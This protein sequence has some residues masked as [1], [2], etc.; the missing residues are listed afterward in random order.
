M[1]YTHQLR[2]DG[3]GAQYQSIIT[4]YI[5]C[6]ENNLNYLYRPFYSVEHNYENDTMYSNK[7]EELINV[8][9]NIPNK[10]EIVCQQIMGHKSIQLFE[11]NMDEYCNSESM[12]FIKNCFWKNKDR[13]HFKNDKLNIAVQIRRENIHD[14]GQ[15]GE[16]STTPNEYYLRIMNEIRE[17]NKEQDKIVQFHI[18]SQGD[19]INFK[20]LENDDVEFHLNE[21]ITTTFIG[22]VAAE[23]L[24]ISPSSFSYV[25]GLLSDG[26]VYYKKFWHLP[27]KEWIISG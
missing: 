14:K 18:Y 9:D 8:K 21:E 11:D 24:I 10:N 13:N 7:L 26:I 15:S 16:R 12:Q 19:L 6:N 20:I 22:L 17:K 5:Y 4:S 2:T 27:K 1:S 3:F 23:I 25:A